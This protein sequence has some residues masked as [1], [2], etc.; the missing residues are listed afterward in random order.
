M[1]YV[2]V[3]K[4]KK[5]NNLYTGHTENIEKRIK[6][7]NSGK[8]RSTSKRRPFVLVYKESFNTRSQARWHERNFKTAWG[9]KQLKS[10]LNA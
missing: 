5:D 7:H 3:L 4:S 1:Y 10:F 8:V 2:Y 9:K 6:E